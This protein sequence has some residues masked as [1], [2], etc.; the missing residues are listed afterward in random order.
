M[1]VDVSDAQNQVYLKNWDATQ[2]IQKII[3]GNDITA[4]IRTQEQSMYYSIFKV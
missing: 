4:V 3:G 1:E 2:A